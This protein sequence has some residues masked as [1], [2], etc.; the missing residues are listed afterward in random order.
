MCVPLCDEIPRGGG[1]GR[2]QVG[3]VGGR[4]EAVWRSGRPAAMEGEGGS[5]GPWWS[6]RDAAPGALGPVGGCGLWGPSWGT[7]LLLT[8]IG[9]RE[10]SLVTGSRVQFRN[11]I[12]PGTQLFKPLL[13]SAV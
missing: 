1:L 6:W 3:V 11:C 4:G 8:K 12:F 10:S 5:S 2:G 13:H 9:K 7:C